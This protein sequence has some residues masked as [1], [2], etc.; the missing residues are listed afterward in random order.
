VIKPD[1]RIFALL[2]ERFGIEPQRAV[3]IDDVEANVTAARP[4][5][6]H[7]I[8]FRTPAKLREELVGLGLLPSCIT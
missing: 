7:A 4:L 1:P 8:H 2:T 6:I 3:Y 5:G